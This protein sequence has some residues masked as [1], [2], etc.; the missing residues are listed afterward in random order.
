MFLV[1]T[2][3]TPVWPPFERPTALLIEDE[4]GVRYLL[5]RVL[6]PRLC[7]IVEAG[8]AEAGL[9][10]LQR[11]EPHVDLVLTDLLLPGLD[12]L[13]VI[14]VLGQYRPDLPLLVI[15]AY[16]G[17]MGPA[18]RRGQRVRVLRKPFSPG[19]LEATA[20]DL[21]ASAP[22]PSRATA[23]SARRPAGSLGSEGLDLVSAAW[24]IHRSRV[25]GELTGALPPLA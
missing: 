13:D 20:A 16:A 21:I 7:D 23:R 17:A 19:E 25:L 9:T 5:R 14:D 3:L 12:G 11:D 4:G 22:K 1:G 10:L 15:S 8:D 2:P 24:A 18:F 6:E